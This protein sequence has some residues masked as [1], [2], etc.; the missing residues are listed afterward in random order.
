MFCLSED[1]GVIYLALTVIFFAVNLIIN[2]NNAL[3]YFLIG[4]I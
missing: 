1:S 3:N 2:A 4:V